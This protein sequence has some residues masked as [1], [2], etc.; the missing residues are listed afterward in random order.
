MLEI[1]HTLEEGFESWFAVNP[2]LYIYKNLL[3]ILRPCDLIFKF[4]N[5]YPFRFNYA[6][7]TFTNYENEEISLFSHYLAHFSC[8]QR[9][10]SQLFGSEYFQVQGAYGAFGRISL[11]S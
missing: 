6:S 3:G 2:F 11:L 9:K 8:R 10:T 1:L 4:D 7:V 5:R